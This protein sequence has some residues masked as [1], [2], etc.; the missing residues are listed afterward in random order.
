[1]I[2]Q[3]M[4]AELMDLREQNESLEER[5]DASRQQ[6]L[7]LHAMGADVE[8]GPLALRV[9]SREK[10]GP[11]EANPVPILGPAGFGRL[12]SLVAPTVTHDVKV[13]EA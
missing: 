11:T 10:R 1:M 8:P 7:E 6:L 4:L 2:T 5:C 3:A 13:H 12:R 9:E